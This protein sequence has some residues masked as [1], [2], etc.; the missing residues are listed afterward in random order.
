MYSQQ[1]RKLPQALKIQ[2][3]VRLNSGVG[4]PKSVAKRYKVTPEDAVKFQCEFN[5]GKLISKTKKANWN[6]QWDRADVIH[7]ALD[8]DVVVDIQNGCK[9]QEDGLVGMFDQEFDAY[10][11][12][13]HVEWSDGGIFDLLEA[14]P[15]RIL[16]IIRD[17]EVDSELYLEA[18]E[19]LECPMFIEICKMFQMDH[20]VLLKQALEITKADV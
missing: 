8:T 4:T 1:A 13:Y 19:W 3:A 10:N 17:A 14:I 7:H 18:I 20:Q 9:K 6:P 15:Y 16:E 12:M 11:G 2:A 5:D